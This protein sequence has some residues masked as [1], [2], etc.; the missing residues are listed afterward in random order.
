M[1]LLWKYFCCGNCGCKCKIKPK[2]NQVLVQFLHCLFIITLRNVR[3]FTCSDL[4]AERNAVPL[5]AIFSTIINHSWATIRYNDSGQYC[6]KY[7]PTV[8]GRCE[9]GKTKIFIV[10]ICDYD[11][12][13]KGGQ[14]NTIA[15]TL[16]DTNVCHFEISKVVH[17]NVRIIRFFNLEQILKLSRASK[18]NCKSLATLRWCAWVI[19][20]KIGI[21]DWTRRMQFSEVIDFFGKLCTFS[22]LYTEND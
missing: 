14:E 8:I 21:L 2:G 19:T 1:N 17:V 9:N 10:G 13:L 5:F 4:P 15:F 6:A 3:P 22:N 11:C 7:L 20:I 16:L 18:S 12:K